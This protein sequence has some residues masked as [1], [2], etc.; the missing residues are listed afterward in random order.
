MKKFNNL[1]NRNYKDVEER[2]YNSLRYMIITSLVLT[3]VIAALLPKIA[4][5]YYKIGYGRELEKHDEYVIEDERLTDIID[6]KTVFFDVPNELAEYTNIDMT[7][8]SLEKEE[9][10]HRCII[11]AYLT[12]FIW[13]L[14]N[15][16]LFS[17]LEY[18]K[19]R[20]LL[21]KKDSRKRKR[22]FHNS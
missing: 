18:K 2:L 1:S 9:N 5:V 20:Y 8:I 14:M 19:E 11:L 13:I 7:D 6:E 22:N 10:M 3:L 21:N 15:L 17:T 16:L 12:F 4:L